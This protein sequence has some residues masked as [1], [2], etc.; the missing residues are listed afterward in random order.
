VSTSNNVAAAVLS[1]SEITNKAGGLFTTRLPAVALPGFA[2][3][4]GALDLTLVSNKLLNAGTISSSANLNLVARG[5]SYFVNSTRGT[6][7]AAN[8]INVNAHGANNNDVVA[9][10]GG[11]WLSPVLNIDAGAGRLNVAAQLIS[12]LINASAGCGNIGTIDG[13]LNLGRTNFSGD[14]TFWSQN[15][16][17]LIS[18]LGAPSFTADVTVLAGQDIT[19]DQSLAAN[20]HNI[21]LIAGAKLTPTGTPANP[22]FLSGTEKVTASGVSSTGGQISV[23]C[24]PCT[25]DTS[26]AGNGGRLTLAHFTPRLAPRRALSI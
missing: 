5:N 20:G 24:N 15:G 23:T 17:V 1:A 4:V 8:A 6:L 3:A 12:G 21:T 25:I 22:G 2:N 14:P 19:I 13:T 26:S 16:S 18:N 10:V 9:L 7:E 11:K